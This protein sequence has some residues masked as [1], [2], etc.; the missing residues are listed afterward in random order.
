MFIF[1]PLAGHRCW[2]VLGIRHV[3]DSLSFKNMFYSPWRSYHQLRVLSLNIWEWPI[4]QNLLTVIL[5]A[6]K[7]HISDFQMRGWCAQSTHTHRSL[8]VPTR[9][10]F[11]RWTVRWRR[12]HRRR[13]LNSAREAL[14]VGTLRMQSV[15]QGWDWPELLSASSE[16]QWRRN[17]INRY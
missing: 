2:G 14:K 17:W 8:T 15:D 12:C 13:R 1:S 11:G 6:G 7:F 3:S 5:V 16:S 4:I 10:V 9:G